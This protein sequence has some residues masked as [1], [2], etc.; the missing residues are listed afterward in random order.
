MSTPE[1][2]GHAWP[3]VGQA[4]L[5][6]MNTDFTERERQGQRTERHFLWIRSPEFVF[7]LSMG[8]IRPFPGFLG[9][10][11][12]HF[13]TGRKVTSEVLPAAGLLSIRQPRPLPGSLRRPQ[14]CPRAHRTQSVPHLV[15]EDRPV[16][17]SSHRWNRR[18]PLILN[19]S[20]T[21]NEIRSEYVERIELSTHER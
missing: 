1:V 5:C 8:F 3:P 7:L 18:P 19:Q 17:L 11:Y 6:L 10:V 21:A 2:P 14:G 4:K 9:L 15:S 12:H 20:I 16:P 13:Y